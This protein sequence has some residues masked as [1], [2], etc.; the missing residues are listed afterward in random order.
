VGTYAGK[1]T[2]MRS[3]LA[4]IAPFA[5]AGAFRP[6]HH[7]CDQWHGFVRWARRDAA[8]TGRDPATARVNWVRTRKSPPVPALTFTTNAILIA[9]AFPL[10]IVILYAVAS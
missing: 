6:A 2:Y 9:L 5:G 8:R 1:Q 10:A 3:T 7:R 4:V